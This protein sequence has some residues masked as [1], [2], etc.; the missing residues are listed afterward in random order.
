MGGFGRFLLLVVL[1]LSYRSLASSSCHW[2]LGWCHSSTASLLIVR[3]SCAILGVGLHIWAG[4]FLVWRGV[5]SL[6]CSSLRPCGRVLCACFCISGC[7]SFAWSWL[8]A[9]PIHESCLEGELGLSLLVW[10]SQSFS[11]LLARGALVWSHVLEPAFGRGKS[12]FSSHASNR[13]STLSVVMGGP[14]CIPP[15]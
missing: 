11:V 8:I 7:P 6:A 13:V 5:G 9:C 12:V 14:F 15:R 2:L 3:G 10:S 1:G 4:F